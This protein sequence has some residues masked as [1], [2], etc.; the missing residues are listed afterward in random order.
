MGDFK[1]GDYYENTSSLV[2][3]ENCRMHREAV[4]SCRSKLQELSNV[5]SCEEMDLWKNIMAKSLY[6][7]CD[8]EHL[9]SSDDHSLLYFPLKNF[10]K[11]SKNT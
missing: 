4:E 11:Y 1:F 3:M 7:L 9:S 6:D 5:A 2:G 10:E 8:W